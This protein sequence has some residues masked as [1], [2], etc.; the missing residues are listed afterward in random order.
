[1]MEC[2]PGLFNNYPVNRFVERNNGPQPE[3]D[4][5]PRP[6]EGNRMGSL[7]QPNIPSSVSAEQNCMGLALNFIID[8]NPGPRHDTFE[9]AMVWFT[10]HFNDTNIQGGYRI[11]Y[12]PC[13]IPYH[14]S[15]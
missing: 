15:H 14:D 12:W 3:M 8:A 6:Y 5:N 4:S 11:L 7:F 10:E 1:M 9:D 2:R 13:Y